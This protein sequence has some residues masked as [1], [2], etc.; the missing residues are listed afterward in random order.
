MVNKIISIQPVN[1]KCILIFK[2]GQRCVR[3]WALCEDSDD[4]DSTYVLPMVEN[5]GALFAVDDGLDFVWLDDAEDKLKAK[6]LM[7]NRGGK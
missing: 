2:G 7:M 4:V 5:E 1:S 3:M 6:V